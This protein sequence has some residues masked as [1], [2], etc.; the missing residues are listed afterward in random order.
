MELIVFFLA[1][2]LLD[3]AAFRWGADSRER[4]RPPENDWRHTWPTL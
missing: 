1:L 3:W 4:H 2:V